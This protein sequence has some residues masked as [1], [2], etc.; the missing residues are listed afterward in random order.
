MLEV[1]AAAAADEDSA[2][3]S[4]EGA[5]SEAPAKVLITGGHEV[6]GL[7]SFA[8]ALSEGFQQLG[9]PTEIIP[10]GRIWS[11]W[12]ELRDPRVLKILSTTAVFAAPFSRRALCVSHG[13][14][15]ADVQGW[16]KVFGFLLSYKIANLAPHT[17]LI[18]VS[19]YS[20]I[21][22]VHIFNI[23]FD[24]VIRNPVQSLFLQPFTPADEARRYITYVGRLHPSK[25]VH[26]LLPAIRTV[27][28]EHPG[29]RAC[30]IGDGVSR[31]PL[32]NLYGS[33]DRIEFTGDLSSSQ[34]R[35]RLRLTRVFLSGN[36][37]EP[38]GIT[39]LEALSQGCVVAMPASGGGL[40]IAPDLIGMQIHL[41]PISLE[42]SGVVHT[43][44]RALD[45]TGSPVDLTPYAVTAVAS[46]YLKADADRFNPA[47][48]WISRKIQEA[49]AMENS[50]AV[51]LKENSRPAKNVADPVH[52]L[53]YP[54]S[55]VQNG[56]NQR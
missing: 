13:C 34:V 18:S 17:P 28:D 3:L 11:R 30:I 35:E 29:L 50:P 44:R 38:F 54:R 53:T 24:T 43:L 56:T 45:A 55:T 19:E 32:E 25:N 31:E 33:D 27:L 4:T 42:H 47:A 12:R 8:E 9:I 37:T 41:L 23:R 5:K 2:N 15:C 48:R 7:T 36:Q 10:P 20:A 16:S 14:P 22:L 40:E 26:R 1:G 39:F 51:L 6:G 52:A 49:G 46:A 21:H